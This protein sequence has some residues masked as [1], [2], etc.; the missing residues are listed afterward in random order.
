MSNIQ[1]SDNLRFL[2]KRHKITQDTISE[3][4]NISRQA[5]SNYERN[6]RMPDLDIL[7]R[8]SQFYHITIDDLVLKNLR[9]PSTFE[10]IEE[11][12]TYYTPAKERRSG[13]TIY[14]QDG[15]LELLTSFRALSA[16]D[17][18]ILSRFLENAKKPE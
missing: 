12:R 10:R 13:K 2:R 5:Y 11:S 16:E 9:N 3:I 4:L 7:L 8:L 17:R 6:E 15:E 18:Q 1:L 14:L